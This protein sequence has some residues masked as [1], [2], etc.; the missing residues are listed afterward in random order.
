MFPYGYSRQHVSNH[1]TLNSISKDITDAIYSVHRMRFVYGTIWEVI[2]P[3]SGS[4]ADWAYDIAN[5]PCSF[6]PELRDR[7]Q[8]GFLLPENQIKPVAEEM[9]EAYKAWGDRVLAGDCDSK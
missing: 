3:A 5:I 2:Y 6:A 1:N 9:W 8:Y 4:S 7:G